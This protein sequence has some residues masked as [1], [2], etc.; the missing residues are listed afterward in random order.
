MKDAIF[1]SRPDLTS[2]E[3]CGKNSI[4]FTRAE[5]WSTIHKFSFHYI[6]KQSP[7][8]ST[9]EY[10][11][12]ILGLFESRQICRCKIS[13]VTS[14]LSLSRSSAHNAFIPP[15]MHIKSGLQCRIS[16][17]RLSLHRC[18]YRARDSSLPCH[19]LVFQPMLF[20]PFPM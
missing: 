6:G 16:L 14:L 5:N 2:L 11:N 18:C 10:L 20:L 1:F 8:S 19:C 13:T 15:A 12:F 7:Q 17:C 4:G 3:V 9:L